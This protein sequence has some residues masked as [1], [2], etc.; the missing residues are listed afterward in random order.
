MYFEKLNFNFKI[1][2]FSIENY[3][4]SY[5]PIEE[6]NKLQF[7]GLMYNTVSKDN[8]HLLEIIPEQ[9]RKFFR[10]VHLKIN[11]NV[12]PHIDRMVNTSINFYI[13]PSEC[14]TTFYSFI[15][16]YTSRFMALDKNDLK[17]ETSFIA[18]TNDV[19]ILDVSKPHSVT[20]LSENF[21]ERCIL[22]LQTQ[23]SFSNVV[24]WILN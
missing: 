21:S 1:N 22:C 24:K 2:K 10:I 5:P 20:S 7:K 6:N 19:Y 13:K 15:N 18:N 16:Q 12:H 23:I 17:E 11:R 3:L 14:K 9:Y 4:V 8:N